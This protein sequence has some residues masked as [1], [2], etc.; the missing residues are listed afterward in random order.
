L[1]GTDPAKYTYCDS[2]YACAAAPIVARKWVP[3]I[4]C[5]LLHGAKRYGEIRRAVPFL[6]AKVLTENLQEMEDEGMLQRE[7]KNSQP[8][9]V[10]Y[11]LTR[12][13]E[14]LSNVIRAM[15]SWGERWL[16]RTSEITL[17]LPKGGGSARKGMG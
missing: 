16:R 8:I 5:H 4:V 2:P 12:K 17:A 15:N 10:W 11:R 13:G 9:E 3:V 7:V 1:K 14:D 6:S